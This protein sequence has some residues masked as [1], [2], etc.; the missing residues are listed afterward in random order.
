MQQNSPAK[1][2]TI[3][4]GV[5]LA[6]VMIGSVFAPLLSQNATTTTTDTTAVPPTTV[7]TFP[8]PPSDFSVY[9]FNQ[10]YLHPS[11]IFTIGQP[12]GWNATNPNK[13]TNIAQVNLVNNSLYS[14]V[15][16]YIEAV[17]PPITPA[18]LSAHFS[19]AVINASWTNFNQWEE[20]SRKMDGD[21][22]VIDF[23]ITLQSRTY[24]AR[25]IAWTDGDWVYTVRVLVPENAVDFLKYLL[26]N[27]VSSLQVQ[28][29]FKGMPL[30]WT[31]YYDPDNSH[32]IRYPA[33]W[34]LVDSAPGRPT[35]ITGSGGQQLRV[36]A[37]ANT[38]IA[39][40]AAARAFAEALSSG[41]KVVSVKPITRLLGQG[42]AVAY[43]YQTVDGSQQSG[44]VDLLNSAD[45]T[46]HIADLRFPMS[47]VDL[48]TVDLNPAPAAAATAEATYS[49]P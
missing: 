19:E 42:F 9:T 49:P 24:V 16:S 12:N 34:T 38:P 3:I 2:A 18:D 21:R 48:N 40:E 25:Q 31:A 37:R 15:D 7:A 29:E 4:L 43:S 14:V 8:P 36:E 39:D 26:D 20:T 23:N 27:F 33:D 41:N 22:L 47:G 17:S 11:G 35:S 28:S 32:I 10:V 46:L 1:R 44:L 45:G 5:L 30:D 6:I 13:G